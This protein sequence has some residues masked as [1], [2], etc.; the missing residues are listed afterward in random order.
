L[1][2]NLIVSFNDL[3]I[4]FYRVKIEGTI[5]K[6]WQK[7]LALF[8]YGGMGEKIAGVKIE[9]RKKK[10]RKKKEKKN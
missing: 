1:R 7:N 3:I 4:I 6:N 9:E 8:I 5:I 10:N 2:F